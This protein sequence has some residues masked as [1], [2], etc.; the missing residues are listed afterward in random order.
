MKV[1][2]AGVLETFAGQEYDL[3]LFCHSP[4]HANGNAL[5]GLL[6]QIVTGEVTP[7]SREDILTKLNLNP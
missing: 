5:R 1:A 3:D 4:H 2:A 7:N 6:R